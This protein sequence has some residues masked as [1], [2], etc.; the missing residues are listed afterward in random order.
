MKRV[1]GQIWEEILTHEFNHAQIV[2]S[3]VLLIAAAKEGSLGEET[4]K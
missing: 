4:L 2:V 3:E 1:N